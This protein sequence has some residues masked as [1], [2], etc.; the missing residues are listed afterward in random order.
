M[1]AIV[2]IAITAGIALFL[3]SI[4]SLW[5]RTTGTDDPARRH[6]D[7]LQRGAGDA[8]ARQAEGRRDWGGNP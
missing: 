3:Y 6:Q 8:A 4:V 2:Y 7:H 1:E 5:R